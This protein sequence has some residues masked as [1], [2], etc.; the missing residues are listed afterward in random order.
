LGGEAAA[1]AKEEA[2][3]AQVAADA[4]AVVEKDQRASV[5]F[6]EQ[7]LQIEAEAE[8]EAARAQEDEA[9]QKY[10]AEEAVIAVKAAEEAVIA[11]KAAEE[12]AKIDSMKAA[13]DQRDLEE[14]DQLKKACVDAEKL[15]EKAA[16]D[17]ENEVEASSKP[18]V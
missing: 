17:A 5:Q 9:T 10:E 1:V 15:Q 18:L 2:S 14:Y 4:D 16:Q 12:Q 6:D 11:V 13:L 3:V 8:A 7:L